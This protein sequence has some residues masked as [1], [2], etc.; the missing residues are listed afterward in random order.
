[1]SK[2][3]HPTFAELLSLLFGDFYEVE[4]EVPTGKIPRTGDLV[5]SRRPEGPAPPFNGLWSNLTEWNV[6]EFKGPTDH[7]EEDD[8]DLLIHVGSGIAY[9]RNEERRSLGQ[10]R[11]P[12]SRVS[13]WYLAPTLG[14]TFLEYAQNRAV[15]NYQT[16]G[17]WRPGLGAS[18]IPGGLL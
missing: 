13:F 6:T 4:P 12:N 5:V 9:E 16:G 14:P 2:Q 17:L 1:M 8:L 11:L 18:G 7:A 3:W 10:A 15:F